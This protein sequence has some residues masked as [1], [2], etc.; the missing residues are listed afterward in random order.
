LAQKIG[1]RGREIFQEAISRGA[2]E[3]LFGG[4]NFFNAVRLQMMMSGSI[5]ERPGDPA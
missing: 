3:G 5:T 1:N 2:A 4:G